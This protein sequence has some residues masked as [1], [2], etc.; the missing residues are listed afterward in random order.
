[1]CNLVEY[2]FGANNYEMIVYAFSFFEVPFQETH[3]RSSAAKMCGHFGSSDS[4]EILCDGIGVI[5]DQHPAI[6]PGDPVQIWDGSPLEIRTPSLVQR[7]SS[8]PVGE[9]LMY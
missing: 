9:C 6:F 8:G 4:N 1:M 5:G 3:D 7:R 2:G